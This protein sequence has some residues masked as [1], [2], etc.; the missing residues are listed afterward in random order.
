MNCKYCG[1]QLPDTAKFCAVCGKSLME[2]SQ[3]A[4][5]IVENAAAQTAAT[6]PGIVENAAAQT[7]AP[8]PSIVENAAA[9][10]AAPAADIAE[11]AAQPVEQA[12]P[13]DAGAAVKPVKKSRLPLIGIIC[14]SVALA[15]AVAAL[16][17]T[18]MAGVKRV[19]MGEERYAKSVFFDTFDIVTDNK[20]IIDAA[21]STAGDSLAALEDMDAEEAA[22]AAL[23]VANSAIG[24]EGLTVSAG[25]D[26]APS[27]IAYAAA[28]EYAEKIDLDE[29]TVR[30]LVELVNGYALTLSEKTGEDAYQF[31]ASFGEEKKP[32]FKATMYYDDNGDAYIAFPDAT[33]GAFM[34]ELPDIPELP[35]I[36]EEDKLK[37]DYAELGALLNE[38][39]EVFDEYYEYAEVSVDKGVLDI[40]GARFEGQCVEIIFDSEDM[41]DMIEDMADVLSHNHYLRDLLEDNLDGFDYED[42]LIA[43]IEDFIDGM[44]EADIEFAYRGYVT[45]SNKLA[46]F[47]GLVY[48]DKNEICI[49]AMNSAEYAAVGF[50]V[51]DSEGVENGMY[52]N[53][54][55][56]D[57]NSGTVSF[58]IQERNDDDFE[59]NFEYSG[60]GT[61]KVFGQQTFVGSLKLLLDDGVMDI[62]E[63]DE[64]EEIEIGGETFKLKDVVE[65]SVISLGV[66]PEGKGLRYEVGFA[67]E[68]LGSYSV[69]ACA[70]PESGKLASNKFST[71]KVVDV[72]DIADD[73]GVE[74]VEEIAYYY[75]EKLLADDVLAS[76]FEA[77]GM[78]D[79]DDLIE[80]FTGGYDID[81]YL[82]RFDN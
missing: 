16:V 54:V 39:E 7:A 32:L 82:Q 47:E 18:N 8:A 58:S 48:D 25:V 72:E 14:G 80:A 67:C 28:G 43:E 65:G 23:A 76:V 34:A 68:E 29:A 78:D 62:L 53:A 38:L 40:D 35:E 71:D 49:S 52:I 30:S 19:F 44:D 41:H 66:L 45:K 26:F 12:V 6:A 57:S 73:E 77:A 31:A 79:E 36:A 2:D 22:V 63:L 61:K 3:P 60:I 1:T 37:L 15:G 17:I 21:F 20:D 64:S 10:T 11:N 27:E 51:E 75:A 33:K 5:G 55:K 70:K 74:L 42:D 56:A 69:Y 50:S 24:V 46:G 59:L 9:Q 13:A 81:E 4:S